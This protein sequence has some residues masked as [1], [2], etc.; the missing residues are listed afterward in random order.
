MS[1]FDDFDDDYFA[2]IEHSFF[3]S[4]EPDY[5]YWK[6]K[7]GT[8]IPISKMSRNHLINAIRVLE[9]SN[10]IF[11]YGYLEVMKNELNNRNPVQDALEDFVE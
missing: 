4:F 11:R 5:D 3:P 10:H 8:R 7:D 1:Y 6:L 2:F 9:Q